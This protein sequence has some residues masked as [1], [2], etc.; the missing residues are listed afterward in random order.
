MEFTDCAKCQ[1]NGEHVDSWLFP[2]NAD[3]ELLRKDSRHLDNGELGEIKFCFR[4][5]GFK[6]VSR[7]SNQGYKTHR[8]AETAIATK[9]ARKC[10]SC[11]G[12]GYQRSAQFMRSC[13]D[14]NGKGRIPNW[15]P[16]VEWDSEWGSATIRVP[17]DSVFAT[18]I[19]LIIDRGRTMTWGESFLGLGSVYTLTD[20]GDASRMDDSALLAKVRKELSGRSP[21]FTTLLDSNKRMAAAL[22]VKVSDMGYSLIVPNSDD[23]AMR[24]ALPPT[25]FPTVDQ[26]I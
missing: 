16:G 3:G 7:N 12:G 22:I 19:P 24:N 21:Q 15:V 17:N 26:A 8:T 10:D 18:T 1:G 4:C 14:C 20:Y 9:K 2:C 6:V 11:L 23:R 25:Y 5:N 13:Y